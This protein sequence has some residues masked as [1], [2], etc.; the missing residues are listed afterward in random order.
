MYISREERAEDI[1]MGQATYRSEEEMTKKLAEW[2]TN[3]KASGGQ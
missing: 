1:V 2:E 3:W